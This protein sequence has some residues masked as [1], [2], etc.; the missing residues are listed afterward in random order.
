[1]SES[2]YEDNVSESS[3][4]TA[5][6]EEFKEETNEKLYKDP[7]KYVNIFAN[8]LNQ[9]LAK[10]GINQKMLHEWVVLDAFYVEYRK[11]NFFKTKQGLLFEDFLY[12]KC[13][14]WTIF[15]DMFSIIDLKDAKGKHKLQSD[16]KSGIHIGNNQL[17]KFKEKYLLVKGHLQSGKTDYIISQ[18][19]F[20]NMCN[21]NSVIILRN[22]TED[23]IQIKNRIKNFK[24][25]LK[26][27]AED[28]NVDISDITIKIVDS[29]NIINDNDNKKYIYIVI[30]EYTNLELIKNT[31]KNKKYV[32][33]IDE[34]DNVDN[35][36]EGDLTCSNYIKKLK[37]N[38][39][40]TIGV[41]ATVTGTYW[42]WKLRPN[43][44]REI[45]VPKNYTG[46][47]NLTQIAKK[48]GSLKTNINTDEIDEIFKSIPYLK[49]HLDM[50]SEEDTT[51]SRKPNIDLICVTHNIKPN[52]AI[53]EWMCDNHQHVTS[54]C[55]TDTGIELYRPMKKILVFKISG[56]GKVLEYLEERK[57]SK[58][59]VIFSSRTKAGRG[60]TFSSTYKENGINR[61]HVNRMLLKLTEDMT[62]D[63]ILQLVG[64]LCGK[65]PS[66]TQ[67]TLYAS[68][69]DL[70]SIN[71]AYCLQEDLIDKTVRKFGKM[72]QIHRIVADKEVKLNEWKQHEDI[73]STGNK[74]IKSTETSEWK[75]NSYKITKTGRESTV[76]R[77]INNYV[78]PKKVIDDGRHD[79][80]NFMFDILFEDEESESEEENLGEFLLSWKNADTNIAR[81]FRSFK[82]IYKKNITKNDLI[83]MAENAGAEYP[84]A[85]VGHT[86]T[87]KKE[88]GYGVFFEKIGDDYR[89][90]P[91]LYKNF[92]KI[93]V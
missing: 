86:M 65:F 48:T 89:L 42:S 15:M 2:D 31:L 40:L 64:R 92:E 27:F 28:K 70:E 47:D 57:K 84:K 72:E 16:D 66:G 82:K 73:T 3:F 80:E 63:N 67:Q 8:E 32:L 39:Y 29:E 14:D 90:I 56:I 69:G 26:A 21:L 22:S 9:K 60:I 37:E 88:R 53:F 50:I 30:K 5:M 76:T 13:I 46:I 83:K 43:C 10:K 41:S 6:C 44:V 51:Y 23:R 1:M 93:F 38:S 11:I 68:R 91:K 78:S 55:M 4:H 52:K 75:Y 49:Q 54:V 7:K 79:E 45:M 20:F 33:I 59:I 24:E 62:Y 25:E 85:F 87:S 77:I 17:L 12:K 81:F 71:K 74:I 61:W 18:A 19:V 58:K 36:F 35:N 34:V